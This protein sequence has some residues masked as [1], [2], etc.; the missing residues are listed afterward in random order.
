MEALQKDFQSAKVLHSTSSS[1]FSNERTN[2]QKQLEAY[3]KQL[4][5]IKLE[6]AEFDAEKVRNYTIQ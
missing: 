6:K 2:L 1:S 5:Q 3:K 4:T